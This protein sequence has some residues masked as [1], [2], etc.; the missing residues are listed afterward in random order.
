MLFMEKKIDYQPRLQ[1]KSQK[2][3]N[4]IKNNYWTLSR[5]ALEAN[6][7]NPTNAAFKSICIFQI[8]LSK[9]VA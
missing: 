3:K 2:P 4:F 5:C 8:F 6:T 7:S 1:G 9:I